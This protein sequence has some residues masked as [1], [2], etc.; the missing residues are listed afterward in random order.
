[1]DVE[2]TMQFILEQQAQFAS[3]IQ[4]IKETARAQQEQFGS[5][6]G[7]IS[8]ALAGING[9]IAR[10]NEVVL[11]V[12]TAQERANEILATLAERHIELADSHHLLADAHKLLA[13]AHMQ[14]EERLR[15]LI[16]TV[17]RHIANHNSH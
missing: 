4:M 12:A 17:E 9:A 8:S 15:V 11:D 16:D 14:T 5:E 2:G 1:M 7:R 13:D 6:I 3:D 10:T